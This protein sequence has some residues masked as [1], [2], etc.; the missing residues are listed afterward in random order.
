VVLFHT[1]ERVR[2]NRYAKGKGRKPGETL[3]HGITPVRQRGESAHPGARCDACEDL[4]VS[5]LGDLPGSRI[6]HENNFLSF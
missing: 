1:K 4:I 3:D 2:Q 5:R 6:I